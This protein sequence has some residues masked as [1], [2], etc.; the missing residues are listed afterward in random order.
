MFDYR[1]FRDALASA[2][3]RA[4]IIHCYANG[5]LKAF[6]SAFGLTFIAE[7]GDKTQIAILTLSARYGFWPVFLGAALAFVILNGLAVTVGAVVAR[8]VPE[9]VIRYVSAGI[10]IL[11]G[12][13]SFRPEKP[14]EEREKPSGNPFIT[15]LVAVALLEFGD[16][17]QLS[18]MAM[19]SKF[20]YP[21]LVFIGG[22]LAL[23]ATSL[24]GALVGKGLGKVVPFKYVRWVSGVVFI[25]FGILIAAGVL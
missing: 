9:P 8:F 11:F 18:L 10:F 25:V 1:F 5:M 21:I 23:W 17:T 6:G 20:G 3:A 15:S 12:V 16:K 19:T 14:E 22:T 24:L 13:L 4:L 7:I 2:I